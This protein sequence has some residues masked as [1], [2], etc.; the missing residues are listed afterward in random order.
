MNPVQIQ[1]FK[2]Q[3]VI[4]DVPAAEVP[5]DKWTGASNVF[6]D[7]GGTHRAGG[8]ASFADTA[9]E[10]AAHIRPLRTELTYF[11]IY[12]GLGGVFVFDGLIHHNITPAV[13]TGSSSPAD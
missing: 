1:D 10:V 13:Y 8:V 3:G 11:W 5:Q 12:A 4:V 6:F 2:L 9:P 7:D